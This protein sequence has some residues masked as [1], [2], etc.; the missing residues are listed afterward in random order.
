MAETVSGRHDPRGHPELR[1]YRPAAC[2]EPAGGASAGSRGP[3]LSYQGLSEDVGVAPNT[4]RHYIVIR[5]YPHHRSI[6][7]SLLQQPKLYFYDVGLARGAAGASLENVVALS[8]LRELT[9][10]EDRD[11]K[12]RALRYLR[13]KE[14]HEVDFMLTEEDGPSLMVEVNT[15]DRAVSSGLRYF[16]ERYGFPGVQ[17]VA[18]LHQ[19]QASGSLYVRRALDWLERPEEWPLV[20]TPV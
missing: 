18:D 1:E 3:P 12:P 20:S 17:L 19:E 4:I 14:G 5:I 2:H 6:A 16:N 9:L 10:R 8:L 11:G 15:H 13:T 7:R